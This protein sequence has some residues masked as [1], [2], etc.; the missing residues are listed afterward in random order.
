MA[1][2]GRLGRLIGQ[3]IRNID[4][5]KIRRIREVISRAFSDIENILAQ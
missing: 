3:R 1:E 5:E 4:K 2:I